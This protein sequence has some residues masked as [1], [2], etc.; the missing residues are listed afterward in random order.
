MKEREE[1]Q[2]KPIG[3]VVPFTI[4]GT[5]WGVASGFFLFS[6]IGKEGQPNILLYMVFFPGLLTAFLEKYLVMAFGPTLVTES[7][8]GYLSI[9]F[10]PAIIFGLLIGFIVGLVVDR[11]L[12]R[13]GLLQ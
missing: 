5:I 13:F 11:I 4:A 1:K 7:M 10:F 12:K 8:I 9:L 6:Q 3:F 2:P